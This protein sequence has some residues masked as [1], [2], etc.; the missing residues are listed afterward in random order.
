MADR[1][2]TGDRGGGVAGMAVAGGLTRHGVAVDMVEKAP[3][4]GGHAS[5]FTCKATDACVQCGACMVETL[6][7]AVNA[8]PRLDVFCSARLDAVAREA[9]RFTVTVDHAPVFIDPQRC[10]GCG[11][12][13]DAC[14]R[15]GALAGRS[16]GIAPPL[17]S[18]DPRPLPLFQG[19]RLYAL[20]GRL[21][22][23][24]LRPGCLPPA[25]GPAGGCRGGG[26]RF[27]PFRSGRPCLCTAAATRADR[28]QPPTRRGADSP[29]GNTRSAAGSPMF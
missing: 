11:L 10:N 3:F 22:Q 1:R 21:S 19:P 17:R 28:R 15:A 29:S 16:L 5:G 14:P 2:G 7:T 9:A 26:G 24:C 23:K 6:L 25:H 18:P 8:A 20:P 27:C 13:L 12:C 4:L